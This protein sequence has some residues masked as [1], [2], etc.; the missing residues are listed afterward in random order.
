MDQD[1]VIYTLNFGVPCRGIVI[2]LAVVPYIT[3]SFVVYRRARAA[4]Y[5]F[6]DNLAV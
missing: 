2:L 6:S 3:I 4:S 1:G 5:Y